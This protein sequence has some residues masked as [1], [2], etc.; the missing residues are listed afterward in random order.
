MKTTNLLKGGHMNENNQLLV[1]TFGGGTNSTALL[2]EMVRRKI[3]VDLILFCDV[4]AELPET[5]CHTQM[6]SKW[7][8]AHGMPE[9]TVVKTSGKTLEQDC[10]DR[11]QL[12]SLAYGFKT[13]SQRFKVAPQDK[14]LNNWQ[15]ARDA[16]KRGEK[17]L[18]TIGYDLDEDHRIKKY[19]SDKYDVI[20]PLVDWGMDRDDCIKAIKDAG[21]PQAGKSACFFCPAMKKI[22]IRELKHKHPELMKRA[23]AMEVNAKENLGSVKGLGRSFSWGHYVDQGELFPEIFPEA[24]I[25][26]SC[27][28]Y[29]G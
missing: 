27:G 22:Q 24:Y 23:L 18:K 16:W 28:C 29:D 3:H 20:Y 26:E 19:E 25:E 4:G 17:V 13:C 9:I 12:P 5:Y 6:F 8:V 7:L 14:F 15:P 21:V 1:V 10:L 11:G 2:V